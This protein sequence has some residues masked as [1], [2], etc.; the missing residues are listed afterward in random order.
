MPFIDQFG[1]WR[2][3]L[4]AILLWGALAFRKARRDRKINET[5]RSLPKDSP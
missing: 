4:F 2:L 5:Y 1:N 3:S